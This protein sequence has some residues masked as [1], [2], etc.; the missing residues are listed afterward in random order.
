VCWSAALGIFVAVADAGTNRVMTSPDGAN[1]T[2]RT[3]ASALPW[4]AV[5]WSPAL[6]LF[7]AVAGGFSAT[8]R[9]MTSPDGIT[10]T[11]RTGSP[12]T[13]IWN[14]IAWSP[15]LGMFAAVAGANGPCITS[16][17]GITWTSRTIASA[18]EYVGICWSPTLGKFLAVADSSSFGIKAVSSDGITWTQ[19]TGLP[20]THWRDAA[21]S[22]VLQ[23]FVVVAGSAIGPVSGIF[24][25]P[26]GVT[27]TSR[28]SPNTA[29]WQAVTVKDVEGG[30]VSESEPSESEP[31][32]FSESSEQSEPV[33]PGYENPGG[34]GDRR[35][36]IWVSQNVKLADGDPP[37][38]DRLID[39]STAATAA[40]GIK[41]A[42]AET[43][44]NIIFD[45]GPLGFKQRITEVRWRQSTTASHGTWKIDASDDAV[46]FVTLKSGI[47]L[48]GALVKTYAFT[49]VNSY[50]F[51][52]L[53]QTGG[54]TSA[55]PWLT[56]VEFKI[57]AGT[58][59]TTAMP[60]Y[61]TGDRRARITVETNASFSGD[62]QKLLDGNSSANVLTFDSGQVLKHID[63]VFPGKVGINEARWK[64]SG[65][66]VSRRVGSGRASMKPARSRT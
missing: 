1:W 57:L 20:G 53:K 52:R 17:D 65:L 34:T 7:A 26:D 51:Y 18:G 59:L 60:V 23:L 15:T 40:G 5:A 43:A 37:V 29:L 32:T 3:A 31:P 12:T 2:A 64:Q 56:E 55:T 61:Q 28:T 54:G 62:S 22:E 50:R 11:L 47:T 66:G 19:T 48:G 33:D 4:Q 39:G 27:F 10:W 21:W 36:L 6:G 16:P 41:F 38:M 14:A 13:G 30:I 44:A 58:H 9:V 24:T 63:F 45:F 42:D 8:N 25:S 46:N 49:N 35:G